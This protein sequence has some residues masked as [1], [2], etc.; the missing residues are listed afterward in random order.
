MTRLNITAAPHIQNARGG[1]N[2]P[3][4]LFVH[5]ELANGYSN[6]STFGTVF[7]HIGVLPSIKPSFDPIAVPHNNDDYSWFIDEPEDKGCYKLFAIPIVPRGRN[8]KWKAGKYTFLLICRNVTHHGTSLITVEIPAAGTAG[9]VI[10]DLR[11]T[12]TVS[13]SRKKKAVKRS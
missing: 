2:D 12:A 3:I 1:N 5:A 6:F 11:A 9:E 13:R 10:D 4:M 7:A 8:K